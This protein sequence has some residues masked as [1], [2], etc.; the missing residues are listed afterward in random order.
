MSFMIKLSESRKKIT[1]TILRKGLFLLPVFFLLLFFSCRKSPHT[2]GAT[3]LPENAQLKI[4]YGFWDGL[5]GHSVL[6]DSI[7]TDELLRNMLGSRYDS[8]FGITTANI[9][10]QF[11]LTSNGVSFGD[12][13]IL[14]S[15]VLY[16]RYNGEIY[17]DSSTVQ[18]LHI[19]EL[20]Q[21]MYIDSTYRSNSTFQ[22]GD[23]D[24]ADLNY[25]PAPH[26]SVVLGNGELAD[27]VA[28]QMIINLS[29]I[30]P[31]LGQKI[32][33]ADTTALSGDS[34][35]RDFF[36]GLYFK[37]EPVTSGGALF[38]V[39]FLLRGSQIIL[40][41]HNND[42]DSLQ[43]RLS[44][45]VITPRV[46]TY[47]HDYSVSPADFQQQVINGDTALG[48]EKLYVQGTGGIKTI[49][50]VPDIRDYTDSSRI[51]FNEVK[52]I[53]PGVTKP[54]KAPERLAL[55]K[56]AE[57]SSYVPLIDQYEGDSYFGGKY[58]SSTNEYV[59][60]ITR[61]MQSLYTG[62]EANRGLYLFV[63]GASINPE[64]FVI[65]GNKYEGDT[66]GMRLEIIYTNLDNTN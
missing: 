7:R 10:A 61:Y 28:P 13:P 58:K 27:T 45:N 46:N 8:V 60:R 18:H 52:L 55:V 19:Y 23:I 44:A 56:I 12:N 34:L 62:N 21:D 32:L 65:K 24:Y 9:A 64:N 57:D 11:G 53:I 54:L 40:Y 3:I 51:A 6:E 66:T 35:F 63:S 16:L 2:L 29:N 5:Y 42:K 37:S 33:D 14:D 15:M 41:Y 39:N 47:T 22:Y 43:Y 20:N 17:G 4:V 38:S 48:F 36:K 59:F 30:S 25:K 31:Q 49:L 26:D 50:K 1:F